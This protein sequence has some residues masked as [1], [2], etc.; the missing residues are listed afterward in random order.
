MEIGLEEQVDLEDITVE[1]DAID[2]PFHSELDATVEG[3]AAKQRHAGQ[4]LLHIC[5]YD[6]YMQVVIFW[7]TI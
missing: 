3:D 6:L 7:S 5:Q 4:G 1:A 2:I